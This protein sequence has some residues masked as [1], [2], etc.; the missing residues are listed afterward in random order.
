MINKTPYKVLVVDDEKHC[1]EYLEKIIAQHVPAITQVETETSVVKALKR[2][3]Q[4]PPDL[5]FLDIQMPKLSGLEFIDQLEDIDVR[6][7]FTTAHAHYAMSA[8]RTKAIDYLLKPVQPDELK[9]CIER[10]MQKSAKPERGAGGQFDKIQLPT[11]HGFQ[12]VYPDEIIHC[13]A[14]GS[15]TKVFT[16]QGNFMISKNI[17]AVEA[18]LKHKGF[19]R[20]H[21]SSII[22]LKHLMGY[23]KGNGGLA[24]M[25]NG[26]HIDISRRRK[27]AFLRAIAS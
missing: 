23:K 11:I 13:M 3:V 22:S 24:V 9:R 12:L 26:N 7:I 4:N 2:I 20:I 8:V 17:S 10:I 19:L 5:L 16:Q 21:K 1:V 25:S 27:D 6:V 15:Y 18:L 14:D